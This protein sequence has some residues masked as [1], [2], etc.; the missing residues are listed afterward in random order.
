MCMNDLDLVTLLWVVCWNVQELNRHASVIFNRTSL[1]QSEE[2]PQILQNLYRLPRV[3]GAGIWTKG[4]SDTMKNW[5]LDTVHE[6]MDKEMVLLKKIMKTQPSKMMEK[7]LLDID[8]KVLIEEVSMQAP[9]LWSILCH[10]SYTPQQDLSNK[11]KN[12]DPVSI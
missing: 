11:T 1:A 9:T 7:A 10:A 4:A 8:F 2:L 3:H 5:A 12:P 6:A